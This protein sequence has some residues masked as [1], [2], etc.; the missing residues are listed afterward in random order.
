LPLHSLEIRKIHQVSTTF[1]FAELGGIDKMFSRPIAL[2]L[3]IA[4]V[5][6]S[7]AHAQV[8]VDAAK[9][10]CKQYLTGRITTPRVGRQLA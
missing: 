7:A 4:F 9:I 2:A 8:T 1:V 6:N 10:T 3:L 5:R